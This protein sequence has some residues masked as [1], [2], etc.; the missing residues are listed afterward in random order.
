M[1]A[2]GGDYR[3]VCC[4]E[5]ESL[6]LYL[7]V[8]TCCRKHSDFSTVVDQVVLARYA[9][10]DERKAT[11]HHWSPLVGGEGISGHRARFWTFSSI[12]AKSG[13]VPAEC[14]SSRSFG[15]AEEFPNFCCWES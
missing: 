9:V 10:S 5:R 15:G 8:S 13:M 4:H 7:M 2:K 1:F 12:L 11:G 14:F 3:A 6:L